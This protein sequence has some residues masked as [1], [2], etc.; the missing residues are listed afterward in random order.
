MLIQKKDGFTFFLKG[1][2]NGY[3]V[4]ILN[5]QESYKMNSF[6]IADCL[7]ELDEERTKY[8]EGDYVS[9]RMII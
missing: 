8:K 4:Y 7:I 9:V 1:K 6:A 2:T 5:D 3:S